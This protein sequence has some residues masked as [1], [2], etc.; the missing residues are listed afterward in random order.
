M[1]KIVEGCGNRGRVGEERTGV[2]VM[3]GREGLLGLYIM[4]EAWQI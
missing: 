2:V 1:G 4:M 3:G